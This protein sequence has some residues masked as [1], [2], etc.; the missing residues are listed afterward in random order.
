MKTNLSKL[1]K[2]NHMKVGIKNKKLISLQIQIITSNKI[3]YLNK[4]DKKLLN[5]LNK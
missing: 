4:K 3:K 2:H 5:I 1:Y